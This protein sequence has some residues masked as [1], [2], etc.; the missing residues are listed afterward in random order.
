MKVEDLFLI[1]IAKS[2]ASRHEYSCRFRYTEH[3]PVEIFKKSCQFGFL[4]LKWIKHSYSPNF[5]CKLLP[6]SRRFVPHWDRQK[7]CLQTWVQLPFPVHGTLSSRDFQKKSPIWLVQLSCL[8]R[9]LL[10]TPVCIPSEK[11]ELP[12]KY[13]CFTF[14]IFRSGPY[15]NYV[16]MF[17]SIFDQLSTLVSMFTK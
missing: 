16:S 3:F 8:R 9:G 14:T 1:E 17:L 13:Y 15:F 2:Y 12:A 10:S 7:L 6:E 11:D 5:L 4:K